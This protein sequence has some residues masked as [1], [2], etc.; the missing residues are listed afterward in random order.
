MHH[1]VFVVVAT[2]GKPQELVEM[3]QAMVLPVLI[4]ALVAIG[5]CAVIALND[6]HRDGKQ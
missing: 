4:A 3:A 1:E 5:I 6:V 2:L